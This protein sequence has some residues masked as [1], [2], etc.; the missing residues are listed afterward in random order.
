MLIFT[1]TN[2][3]LLCAISDNLFCFIDAILERE[4]EPQQTSH[5]LYDLSYTLSRGPGLDA[6]LFQLGSHHYHRR[7]KHKY[8]VRMANSALKCRLIILIIVRLLCSYNNILINFGQLYSNSCSKFWYCNFG[9]VYSMWILATLGSEAL[10]LSHISAPQK[11]TYLM[12]N[13]PCKYGILITTFYDLTLEVAQ[14]TSSE[15]KM[16]HLRRVD[17]KPMS[18]VSLL[19]WLS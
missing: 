16:T 19:H 4:R 17:H 7:W 18:V 2:R 14:K 9:H 12:S 3:T 8:R 13:W 15:F 6:H 10:Y 5:K 1:H 11:M